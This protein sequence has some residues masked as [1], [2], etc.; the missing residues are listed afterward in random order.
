MLTLRGDSSRAIG[1]TFDQWDALRDHL[2]TRAPEL[3][4]LTLQICRL[5]QLARYIR[6]HP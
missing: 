6:F 5:L 2:L 3:A 1:E 4:S